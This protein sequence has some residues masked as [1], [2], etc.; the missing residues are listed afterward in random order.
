MSLLEVRGVARRFGGIAALDDVSLDVEA[1]E[2][3]G[4]IGP[5]GS[6]KTTLFNCLGGLDR[7]EAGRIVFADRDLTALPAH[8]RARLG[9]ARTFQQLESWVGMSVREHLVVAV[10]GIEP[11]G[12]VVADLLGR[13]RPTAVQEARIGRV[14]ELL[15]LEGD[16]DR[17]IESLPIGRARL[18]DV[19]RALTTEP[20]L[21]LLDEPSS[22]LDP[23]ETRALGTVITTV[24]ETSGTAILLVEH[25]LRL[26]RQVADRLVVLDAG[27]I[28]T[29]GPT[30][31]VLADER[32]RAAYLG[33]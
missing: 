25:D 30:G 15:G 10:Q 21:V 32:V 27:R 19:A 3:V 11:G 26:V 20:G 23:A 1:G 22:G 33:T 14:V 13:N 12:G 31:E 7:P 24:N 18:V 5:N 2:R 9:M 4:L 29:S 17:P 16:L 8:R 28:L 6:G